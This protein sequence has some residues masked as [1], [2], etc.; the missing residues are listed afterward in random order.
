MFASTS[1]SKNTS[2]SFLFLFRVQLPH[3]L[4]FAG[5]VFPSTWNFPGRSLNSNKRP[6]VRPTVIC[7][8][9]PLH[10]DLTFL[11][12]VGKK[13]NNLVIS[14]PRFW[15]LKWKSLCET[16]SGTILFSPVDGKFL[17]GSGMDHCVQTRL[18]D[19][20]WRAKCDFEFQVHYFDT[21]QISRGVEYRVS[22][23]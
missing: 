6:P 4:L 13:L 21:R 5:T 8:A 7:S 23:S 14:E 2:F 20:N 9:A 12:L 16:I 17:I 11:F 19:I 22:F 18:F 1:P 3:G 10:K 15:D